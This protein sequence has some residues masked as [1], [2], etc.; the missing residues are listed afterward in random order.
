MS[1]LVRQWGTDRI[2]Y[3]KYPWGLREEEAR[4]NSHCVGYVVYKASQQ[5]GP[6]IWS[7]HPLNLLPFFYESAYET[8]V[9]PHSRLDWIFSYGFVLVRCLEMKVPMGNCFQWMT[10]LGKSA[11]LVESN[12]GS[13]NGQQRGKQPWPPLPR[14]PNEVL[15]ICM[16]SLLPPLMPTQ[17]QTAQPLQT[18]D[19]KKTSSFEMGCNPLVPKTAPGLF[20]NFNPVFPDC[21][22]VNLSRCISRQI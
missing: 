16:C 17:G 4:R 6:G 7:H 3:N 12:T 13:Q 11:Y 14:W 21:L 22:H 18:S 1:S 5:G 9:N 8:E 10:G 2:E 19:P 15:T 20:P